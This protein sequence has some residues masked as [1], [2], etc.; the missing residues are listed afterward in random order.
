MNLI[1]RIIRNE[2]KLL[3][4]YFVESFILHVDHEKYLR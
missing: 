3:E 1:K 4:I 2:A